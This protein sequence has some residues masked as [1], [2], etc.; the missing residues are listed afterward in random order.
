MKIDYGVLGRPDRQRSRHYITLETS[1]NMEIDRLA[2]LKEIA[3][4]VAKRGIM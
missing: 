4:T 1:E 3:G 2:L